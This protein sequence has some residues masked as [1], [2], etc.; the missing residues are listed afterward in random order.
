MTSTAGDIA[1][2]ALAVAG[3][4]G[5]LSLTGETLRARVPPG[6]SV[7][8]VETFVARVQSWWVMA[9]L[10]AL[11][12]VLGR[13]G[14]A[15]LFAVAAFA[16]LREFATYTAKAREDHA[17]LALAFF[18]ALPLQFLF[19]ALDR[20]DLFTVF[21]PVHVF[22]FLP[23]LTVMRGSPKRFLARVAET[24]WALMVCVYCASHVPALMTLDLPR[25]GDRGVLLIAFLVIAVQGAEVVG[26]AFERRLGRRPIAPDLSPR[27]WEG[28][29][30]GVLSAA[31]IGALLAWL[32]PFGLVGAALMAAVAAATG[33]LGT[34]VL[35]AIKLERGVRDWSHLIPGQGGILDQAGGV[36]FAAPVFYH[37]AALGW[38]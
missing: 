8:G 34:L 38:G 35:A 24:Q 14:V 33:T 9:I 11:A 25:M 12:L 32:T 28:A 22:L 10:I 13:A 36:L 2:L 30:A 37:L 17:G 26:M 18:V 15:L 27:T 20:P 23:A 31:L 29:G 3:I 4:L 7:P 21:I 6:R 1:L 16:A 5:A 19:V